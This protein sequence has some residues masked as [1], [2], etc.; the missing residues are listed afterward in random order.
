[1]LA[2]L[3]DV[4]YSLG[5]ILAVIILALGVLTTGSVKADWLSSSV[6]WH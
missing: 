5:C 6:G 4:I 1:M 3:A 2:R